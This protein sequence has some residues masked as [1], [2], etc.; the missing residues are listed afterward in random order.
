MHA[1][2]DDKAKKIELELSVVMSCHCAIRSVDHISDFLTKY[3]KGSDLEKIRLHRSKCACLL[4][5][6]IAPSLRDVLSENLSGKKFSLIVD[7][8]TD[9]SVSKNLCIL[10]R[11]FND[12]SQHVETDLLALVPVTDA[13]GEVLFQEIE[14]VLHSFGQTFKNCIGF[15]ADGA[16][17]LVGKNNSVFSRILQTNPKCILVKCIC[18]S[19]ALAVK[20]ACEKLMADVGFLVTEIPA[21]FSKSTLRRNDFQKLSEVLNTGGDEQGTGSLPP[22]MKSSSTRWLTRG[23]VMKRIMDNWPE[24]QAYFSLVESSGSFETRSKGRII[25]GMLKNPYT[26]LF[27]SFATPLIREVE[28]INKMF[29]AEKVDAEKQCKEL[30]AFHR[31]LRDRLFDQ[32]GQ[33]L[34][35]SNV[36]FGHDFEI[37]LKK[38]LDHSSQQANVKSEVASMKQRCHDCLVELFNQVKVRLPDNIKLFNGLSF[39]SPNMVMSHDVHRA[40]LKHLPLSHLLNSE[41]E[42]EYRSIPYHD[43]SADFPLGT[44]KDALEFWAAVALLKNSV[45]EI[46]YPNL[47]HYA[48]ACMT[49]PVSNAHVERVFS[50]VTW[51]KSKTRNRLQLVMMEALL[52]IRM[53]LLTRGGCCKEFEASVDMLNRF[54][55]SMYHK[56]SQSDDEMGEIDAIFDFQD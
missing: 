4:K 3:G 31:T 43:W 50:Y 25:L 47:S 8:S 39:L 24:L 55:S 9:V 21:W 37:E 2:S 20:H 46:K 28:K 15:G 22:F 27:F 53:N 32:K 7:E 29:Q 13:T 17:S 35:L 26:F 56:Y 51:L 42:Q 19:L 10:V 14:A 44:P 12:H 49:L 6:V 11:Y 45:G 5:N 54:S 1:T 33:P 48:L 23:E 40:P 18:H 38:F 34:A 52:R 16:S 36:D 41:I 30:M